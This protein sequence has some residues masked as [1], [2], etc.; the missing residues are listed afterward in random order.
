MQHNF[1][2]IPHE[3]R[4]YPQ[5][6]CWAYHAVGDEKP[7]KLP[8]DAKKNQMAS[9]TDPT[10]WATYDEAV[11]RFMQGGMSGIGFVLTNNDPF[12]FID[13]DDTH[14]DAE[15]F[16]RQQKIFNTF[17]S[18]SERSPSGMGLHIIV[19]GTVPS[20]RKRSFVEVYSNAR[21]MTMTGNVYQPAPI[22]YHQD[23]LMKLWEQ[24]GGGAQVGAFKGDAK[25]IDNDDVVIFKALNASNGD[26]F[27]LLHNGNWQ[28]L[29]HSQSEA[30]FAYVD[31]IA[32]YTQNREQIT[33]IFRNSILGARSK[34]QRNDYV[35]YMVN[36]SFDRMLPPV[37]IDGLANAVNE[38]LAAK[39][40]SM[41]P[42]IL[43]NTLPAAPIVQA[44][45]DALELAQMPTTNITVP[46]GLMGEL[47]NFIYS[48][49]ARPVPET[50]ICAA[51]GLL[52][53]ICGRPYNVSGTGLNLY[54]LMLAMTGIGKEGIASGI[55]NIMAEVE[56]AIPAAAEFLGP[57]EIASGQSLLKKISEGSA[58]FVSI[59]GEFGLKMQQLAHPRASSAEMMLQRVLLDLYNKSGRKQ[60]LRQSIYA[61]KKN[62]T[63]KVRAPAFT[64]LG[65]STPESF[66]NSLDE[67]LI[68]SGLLPRFLIIE[69]HGKRPK[70]N[71]G[72]LDVVPPP[73]L[74]DKLTQLCQ[75][76]LTLMHQ[77]ATIDVQSDEAATKFLDG[78]D[79]AADEAINTENKDVIRQLWNRVHM[80]TLKLAALIAVGNNFTH[81][82][83]T[84]EIAQW[85][86]NVVLKDVSGI[87][88]RFNNGRIGKNADETKQVHEV[89][90][91]ILEFITRDF[92]SVAKYQV[93]AAMHKDK[94]I[95]YSYLQ[96]RLIMLPAF[97]ADRV[98]ATNALKR[99]V[100]A[101]IDDGDLREL[102]R[103]DLANKYGKTGRAITIS[104][105]ERFASEQ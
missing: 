72:H 101:M 8:F 83:I 40:Q 76:S 69:H 55:N 35:N 16:S 60:V 53:G 31:M 10:T 24:M 15:S 25:Q 96:R 9:V 7:T 34:A 39:T 21:Y 91:V 1:D 95:P 41:Q 88:A 75:Y 17:T 22:N 49:S 68:A 57:A 67:G 93:S 80:K 97:K 44:N 86:Y 52:A 11:F 102:P 26:K 3:M 2:N 14:G 81:P 98:G 5:W 43:T 12:A 18:Y 19:K 29:Y 58:C 87:I 42:N 30:D 71:K 13:L 62:N 50:A 59:V 66:Y 78:V 70:L 32:F 51:I 63:E 48:S 6:I 103:Q 99:T 73:S 38:F 46:P 100:T 45:E 27:A 47:A 54:I 92:A 89:I 20:G 61:D 77:G 79:A 82:V 65:E 37:D 36:K 105:I 90:R 28:Q 74:V 4:T 23:I 56:K 64:L 84:L 33:R 94:V 104:N 85:A